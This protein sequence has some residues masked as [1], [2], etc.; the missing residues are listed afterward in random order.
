MAVAA[1]AGLEH[2]SLLAVGNVEREREVGGVPLDLEDLVQP[3]AAVV[4]VHLHQ[5]PEQLGAV[6][7]LR[8]LQER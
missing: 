2:Q 1:L 3:H 6:T 5:R 8:R 4:R 7:S